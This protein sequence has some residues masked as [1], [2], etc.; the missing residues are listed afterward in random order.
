MTKTTDP[1]SNTVLNYYDAANRLTK[2]VDGAGFTSTKAYD[3]DGRVTSAIDGAGWVECWAEM[4]D[5][6]ATA[7][8]TRD[9]VEG[10]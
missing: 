5:E 2:T 10:S 4:T 7:G 9:C 1:D 3:G 6:F 8:W